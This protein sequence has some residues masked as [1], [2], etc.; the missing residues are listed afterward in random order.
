MTMKLLRWV[1]LAVLGIAMVAAPSVSQA[2]VA[3]G[4]SVRIGPPP[5]PV[6]EQPFCPGD[7]YI[8]IPG[9]WAYGPDGYFWVP[10]T[11]VLPP[12]AGLLW[13]PGYWGWGNGFYV[14]H[15]GY[16]GPHVGFYGGINY[17][18]GYPGTGFYGGYWSGGR[19]FY[20]RSVTRVNVT[21]VRN[22]YNRRVVER[23]V[24]RVSYNGGRGG[25]SARPTREQTAFEHERRFGPTNLQERHREEAGRDRGMWASQNHGR[26]NVAATPRPGEF[27]GREGSRSG[28]ENRNADRPPR[29][30]APNEINR[31]RNNR[32]NDRPP[33]ASDRPHN[34][35]ES[36]RVYSDRYGRNDRPPSAN[37]PRNDSRPNR[38]YADRPAPNQN[39]RHSNRM[40]ANE[41]RPAQNAPRANG[42]RANQQPPRQTQS[43][44]RGERRPDGGR[45]NGRQANQKENQERRGPHGR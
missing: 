15:R 37:A 44:P 19:Y 18:F 2:Q 20:N 16:W 4:I 43:N 38:G 34:A 45:G 30:N 36:G 6:Y 9:Y 24:T 8:W 26:P 12:E 7:G 27:R 5:L 22:T 42:Q 21:I 28:R 35:S 13:T 1:S 32:P 31:P 41:A 33:N 10:G 29:G 23:N 25:I 39:A 11:W 40:N 14:W 3:V 17:G